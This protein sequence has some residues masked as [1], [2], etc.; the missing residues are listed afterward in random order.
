MK[1]VFILSFKTNFFIFKEKNHYLI[2][3]SKLKF[4][5]G[6]GIGLSINDECLSMMFF[7]DSKAG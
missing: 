4:A 6:R 2:S 7:A 3:K 1:K 5:P